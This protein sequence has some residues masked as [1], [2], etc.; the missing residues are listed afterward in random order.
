MHDISPDS[1]LL[2]LLRLCINATWVPDLR[3]DPASR[4]SD[5]TAGCYVHLNRKKENK[6]RKSA[7]NGKL[8]LTPLDGSLRVQH[9]YRP[10][11][12][13]KR[14]LGISSNFNI[15][16]I[17]GSI[18]RLPPAVHVRFWIGLQSLHATNDDTHFFDQNWASTL[19]TVVD[20]CQK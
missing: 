20:N 6:K 16:E 11:S 4:M 5:I 8:A 2:D 15:T 13:H 17:P 1:E 7:A 14:S 10:R 19:E 18:P 12:V 3:I 9:V